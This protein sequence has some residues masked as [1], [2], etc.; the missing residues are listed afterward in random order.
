MLSFDT[1]A[2]ARDCPRVVTDLSRSVSG[3]ACL[4]F[5]HEPIQ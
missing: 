1:A 3:D 5:V 2:V 4:S